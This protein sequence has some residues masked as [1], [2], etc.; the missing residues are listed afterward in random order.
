LGDKNLLVTIPLYCLAGELLVRHAGKEERFDFGSKGLF[1][2]FYAS[3][4]ADCEHEILPVREGHRLAL[5][6]NLIG[7]GPTRNLQPIDNSRV[8][9]K[10]LGSIKAWVQ[11][12]SGPQ[13]LV[14]PLEHQYCEQ[15]LSFDRLKGRDIAA[16]DV[17]RQA[18]DKVGLRESAIYVAAS[19]TF[20]I[21]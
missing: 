5:V 7:Q 1:N 21:L 16:V 2:I 3:F 9:K 4:Y 11:N 14:M 12:G 10:V 13:K 18:A 15:S 17:L 20:D 8:I 19:K 6:Y